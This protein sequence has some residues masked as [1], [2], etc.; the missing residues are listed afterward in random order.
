MLSIEEIKLLIEK[1]RKLK[2]SDFQK[3]LDDSLS[4]LEKLAESVDIN[5]Q[6]EINRL[7]KTKEWYA[8]DLDFTYERKDQF[9]DMLTK[10]V[11][12]KIKMF[13]KTGAQSILYNSLE[14]GPGYGRFSRFFLPWRLN[15]YLDLLPHCEEKIKKRFK[16]QQHK[17]IKFYTTNR[18]SCPE[19]DDNAVNFVFSWNT[20]TFFTQ[21][22][23]KEYLDDIKRVLLPGGYVFIHYA[24]CHY[25]FD[26]H[27]AKRGYWNYNTKTAM[28]DIIEKSGYEI[29]EM[30]QFRPGANYAIFKK[31]GNKNPVLY[32][33]LELPAEK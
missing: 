16:P 12:D 14:I 5:N 32:S 6:Q 11:E 9:D 31:P 30:D 10:K 20:F 28:K 1:L 23:I 29:I 24:D 21:E 22:H 7:D 8:K 4:T 33:A 13:A 18:T 25:D 17:L 26:L 27:E 2:G 19:I 15:Y 3:I